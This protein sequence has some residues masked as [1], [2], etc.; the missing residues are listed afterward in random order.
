ML[1]PYSGY[2]LLTFPQSG[3]GPYNLY[4]ESAGKLILAGGGGIAYLGLM[5]VRLVK[6]NVIISFCLLQNTK[7]YCTSVVGP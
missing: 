7:Y 5:K 1:N 6:H 2:S 3:E 4:R